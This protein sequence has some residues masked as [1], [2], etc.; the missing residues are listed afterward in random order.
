MEFFK[1]KLTNNLRVIQH[2]WHFGFGSSLVIKAFKSSV[3]DACFTP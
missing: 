3:V 1:D 2:A